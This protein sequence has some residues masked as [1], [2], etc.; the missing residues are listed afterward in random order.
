MAR[1]PLHMRILRW[2]RNV[3]LAAVALVILLMAVGAT[4]EALAR[5]AVAKEFPP[6]GKL[7]DIGGRRLHLDCRGSGSPTVVFESGLDSIGSLSWASVHDSVAAVTRACAYDRAGIMWSDPKRTPQS[8]AAIADDLQAALRAAGEAGPLVLVGH[9]LGGPYI[10]TYT[11]KYP[12]QVAGLVF[13]DASHPD[14]LQRLAA[15]GVPP[16]PLPAVLKLVSAL[17]WTGLVRLIPV[18][19][20]H[21]A[22]ER[23]QEIVRACASTSFDAALAE[24]YALPQSLA[25]GGELRDLG[26]RPLVVLTAMAPLPQAALRALNLSAS[27]GR[28]FR[29]VWKMLQDDEASWSTRSR[30]ELFPEAGHYIQFDRPDAVIEAVTEVVNRVREDGRMLEG[31]TPPLERPQ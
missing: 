5:H 1:R 8:A 13:V 11:R 28:R 6:P 3:G 19:A 29:E 23:V 30:H 18:E 10:M 21:H 27:T 15:V 20:P 24:G 9:S 25:A 31:A 16:P 2:L 4:Y 17:S 22:D 26:N 14:Q 7:V 12:D